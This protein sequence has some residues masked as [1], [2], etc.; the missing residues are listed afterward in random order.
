MKKVKSGKVKSGKVNPMFTPA[1]V[2]Y[3]ASLKERIKELEVHLSGKSPN[4]IL[5]EAE[6]LTTEDRQDSYGHPA[7]D[8]GRVSAAFNALT[9]H[10]LTT[11]EA[12]LFMVCVKMA[13]E[14][15][16]PKRDNRVDAA[17][18]LNCLDMV[19]QAR[20]Q[21]LLS[22]GSQPSR[23]VAAGLQGA[24][25]TEKAGPAVPVATLGK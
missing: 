18:Y 16:R 25:E 4:S 8:Y 7:H 15:Y 12:I 24:G 5:S 14:A 11:E 6:H 2:A 13:R 3:I 22:T 10:N 21:G 19:V 9:G 20:D 23:P 1:H 17:G